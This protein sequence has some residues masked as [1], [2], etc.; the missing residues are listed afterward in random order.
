MTSLF[1]PEIL[2]TSSNTVWQFEE[3]C[4]ADINIRPPV[5]QVFSY[6]LIHTGSL[7]GWVYQTQYETENF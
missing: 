3:D 6:I 5:A 4:A 2:L 7:K 1:V